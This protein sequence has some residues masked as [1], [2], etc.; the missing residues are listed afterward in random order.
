MV[1]GKQNGIDCILTVVHGFNTVE[2]R[3]ALWDQLKAMAPIINKHWLISGD[4]NAILHPSDRLSGIT[5]SVAELKDFS[6][7][8]NALLLNEIPWKGEY[9]TWTNKQRGNDRVCS[10]IDKVIANDEWMLQCGHLTAVYGELF[11]SDHTPLLIPMREARRNIKVPFKR[12][13][14]DYR[15]D[16]SR[17]IKPEKDSRRT[18]GAYSDAL[19]NQ[20]KNYLIQLEKWSLIEESALQQKSRATWIKL[21]DSNT[22]FFSADP[23]AIKEEFVSFYKYLMETAASKLPAVNI[24]VMRNFPCLSH[25]QQLELCAPITEE[26]IYEGLSSIGDDKAPGIDDFNVVFFKQTWC[27]VKNEVYEAVQDLFTTGTLYKA[28]NCTTLTLVPKVPNPDTVKDYGPIASCTV[29]YKIT[30][31]VITSRLQ[32]VMAYIILEARA[33]FIPGRKIADNIILAHELIK[34][35]GRKHISLRCMIKVDLQ[36]AYDSLEW[37]YLEQVMEGLRFLEKFIKWVMNCIKTVNYSIILNGESVAPFNAAKGLIQGDPMSHFLFAIAIEYLSRLLKDLQHEKSY[38]FHP[39]CRRLG[40]T[41]LSFVDDL[42][43]FARGDSEYVERLHACF[44]TFSAASGLQANLTKSAVYCGGMAHRE[45]EAIVQQLGYSLGELPFKYLGV[46]LDTKNLTMVQWQSLIAK[47]VAKIS[48]WTANKLSYARRIQLIQTVSSLWS[49]SDTITKKALITWEKICLPKST[50]GLNLHNL[51]VWNNAA[52]AKTHWDLTHKQ[53]KLWI[54]W[55]HAYYIKD[56]SLGTMTIPQTSSWMDRLLT[57]DRLLRWGLNVQAVCAMC[58]AHNETRNHLFA[59]CRYAEAIW[60]KE[61]N[62][63]VFEGVAR[64]CEG[65]AKEIACVCS[66]R[67]AGELKCLMQKLIF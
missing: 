22:K 51:Q 15:E 3:K 39:R 35:Y 37:I 27:I 65:V 2:K 67:G 42:L 8:C 56:Q 4:F 36:K 18:G 50:R 29:L 32:K 64:D 25:T 46:P 21:G 54:K 17:K 58:Q 63:R 40:I 59:E 9:Y 12:V 44:T 7:Y 30:A 16:E 19:V 24:L 52:I 47:I 11:I 6:K 20:E 61:R 62:A 66:C 60:N 26:E 10:R 53:D 23:E 33:G 34:S 41:H 5:I 1:T 43:L 28:I 49:G 45:K 48:S 38:K 55:I 31:K 13:Q 14:G 57:V